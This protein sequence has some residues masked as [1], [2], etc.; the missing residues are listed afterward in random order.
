MDDEAAFGKRF[1]IL[2]FGEAIRLGLLSDYRVV[3]VGV[4][5]ETIANWI[6]N[7]RVRR[8]RNRDRD[9]CADR[10][11]L[12]L[13]LIKAI[14]DWDLQRIISFHSRVKRAERFAQEL[15][16]VC[17]WLDDAHKPSRDNLV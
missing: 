17:A 11:L 15:R 6:R 12:K 14:K 7:R 4:D 16:E 2:P 13:V 3:I 10:S 9:G 8:H 1:H 5:D